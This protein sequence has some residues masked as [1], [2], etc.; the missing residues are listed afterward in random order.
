MS[1]SCYPVDCSPPGSS[2]H[3]IFQARILQ[4]V[5]ISFTKGEGRANAKTLRAVRG[6]A[7]RLLQSSGKGRG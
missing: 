3:G 2:V 6:G 1:D 5:A 4:W 7:W